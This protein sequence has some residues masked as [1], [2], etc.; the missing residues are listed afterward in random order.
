MTSLRRGKVTLISFAIKTKAE[1]MA[2][3]KPRLSLEKCYT[4]HA[5]CVAAAG[6]TAANAVCAE[7]SVAE[8][9]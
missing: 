4:D 8:A 3:G 2:S 9:Y 6:K 1:R 5:G 7:V